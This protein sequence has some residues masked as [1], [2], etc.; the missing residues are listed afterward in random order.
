[1]NYSDQTVSAEP[2]CILQGSHA[3]AMKMVGNA[4]PMLFGWAILGAVFEAAYEVP[5]PKPAFLAKRPPWDGEHPLIIA[6]SA[7]R[8]SAQH[9]YAPRKVLCMLTR[10]TEGWGQ[11]T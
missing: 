4:V 1:M 10:C 5:A 2:P 3:V 11:Q 8:M 9:A 7:P 6:A